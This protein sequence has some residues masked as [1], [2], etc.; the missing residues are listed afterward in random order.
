MKEQLLI[1]LIKIEHKSKF[2]N[3]GLYY[4]VGLFGKDVENMLKHTKSRVAKDKLERNAHLRPSPR[5]KSKKFGSEFG[6]GRSIKKK[7]RFSDAT[8]MYTIDQRTSDT[9]KKSNKRIKKFSPN[10]FTLKSIGYSSDTR[11]VTPPKIRPV[12]SERT[13]L[14]DI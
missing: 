4:L 6:D 1:T 11:L 9:T 2:R 12:G 5:F 8:S 14:Y 10:A 13:W 3:N 7:D